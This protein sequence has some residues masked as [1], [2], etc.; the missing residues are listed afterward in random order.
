LTQGPP[1]RAQ[2]GGA[3]RCEGEEGESREI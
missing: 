1:A 2:E 3:Q